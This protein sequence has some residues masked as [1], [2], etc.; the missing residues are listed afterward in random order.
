[1]ICKILTCIIVSPSSDSSIS[2]DILKQRAPSTIE[3]AGSTY[4]LYEDKQI[5]ATSILKGWGDTEN[6]DIVLERASD[7]VDLGTKSAGLIFKT[8]NGMEGLE[9]LAQA[10]ESM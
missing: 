9:R 2:N 7:R 3:L 10:L 6:F 8:K 1:M 4:Y 5:R